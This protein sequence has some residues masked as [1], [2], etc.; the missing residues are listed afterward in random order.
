[1]SLETITAALIALCAMLSAVVVVAAALWLAPTHPGIERAL[2]FGAVGV[3]L[4]AA[5]YVADGGSR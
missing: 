1:M 2:V 3:V 4:L 5:A